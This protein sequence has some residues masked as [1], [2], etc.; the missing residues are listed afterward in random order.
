MAVVKIILDWRSGL[1]VWGSLSRLKD[2]E[3]G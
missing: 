1:G 2:P 3:G